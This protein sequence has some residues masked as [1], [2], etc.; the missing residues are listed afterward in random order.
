MKLCQLCAVDFTLDRF[1]LPLIDGMKQA[2]WDVVSVCSDGPS[3]PGLRA[4]GYRIETVH[5]PRTL[6]PL[7]HLRSIVELVCLFRG[8]RF[9]AV[10]VHTPVAAMV[11]R[12]AA[13]IAGV[14]L[15]IYTAHGFYF[16][17]EMPAVKRRFFILLE[18]CAGWLT[19]VLFTQS[20]EDADTAVAEG[21]MSSDRVLAIGNGVDT[22]RFAPESAGDPRELRSRHGIPE[23]ALVVGMIARLVREKGTADFLQAARHVAVD[24][25]AAWFLLVGE[26]LASDH[27][28]GVED[29][30]RHAKKELG[31]R[32]V[33]T[34]TRCDIP[35]LLSV[36]DVYCLPSWREGMPRTII[37]AMMMGKPVIATNIRGSREE[38]VPFETGLLV[39]THCPGELAQAISRCVT[40]PEWARSLGAAGRRRAL[41]HYD[42]RRIVAVQIERIR[43]L[44]V[45]RGITA[46]LTLF[47]LLH[48]HPSILAASH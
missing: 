3:L 17:D 18:K 47:C 23:H 35:E 2:G 9:D 28:D 31:N 22:E 10:H 33:M 6:N 4:R 26:R 1:L 30:I 48:A 38:V 46:V 29:E 19:D 41:M 7:A 25:P 40:A 32:L 37:E 24:H 12:L 21:I 20:Q 14:N 27:A 8:H 44:A 36:M 43:G 15:V 16:H 45:S 34:G 13:R 5:L 42:E 39:P 11:G